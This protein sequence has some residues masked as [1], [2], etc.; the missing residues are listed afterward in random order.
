MTG[1]SPPQ[2]LKGPSIALQSSPPPLPHLSKLEVPRN[3]PQQQ[4][5]AASRLVS[6][7]P[8]IGIHPLIEPTVKLCQLL[9]NQKNEI[10]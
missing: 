8:G 9:G 1:C 2:K 6:S 7:T 10:A 5:D 4:D 3:S